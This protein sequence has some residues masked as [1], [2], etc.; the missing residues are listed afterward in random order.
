MPY[1]PKLSSPE[2]FI[3]EFLPCIY[4]IHVKTLVFLL[5]LSFATEPQQKTFLLEE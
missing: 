3:S 1:K 2:L 4:D 5:L